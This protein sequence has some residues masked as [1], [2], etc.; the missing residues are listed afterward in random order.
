MRGIGAKPTA[1]MVNGS[2][3]TAV[4]EQALAG[5]RGGKVI[6][7]R[8]GQAFGA[9]DGEAN[10]IVGELTP[11]TLSR[12]ELGQALKDQSELLKSQTK[13]RKDYLYQRAG[14][15]TGDAPAAG[16]NTRQYMETL[17]AERKAMGQSAALNNGRSIETI[18]EQADA[19][20]KDIGR[21]ANFNA[22]KQAR[23]SIGAIAND[24]GADQV[25]RE[26][27]QGLYGALTKDMGE[28]AESAG[29]GALQA[30]KMANNYNRRTADPKSMFH[31]KT[32]I[33]PIIKAATPEQAAD[34]VL[35]QV[36]KG[37]TRLNAVRRQIERT[38]GGTELWNTLTGSTVERMGITR[39]VDG[40]EAFN[41]T[42]MLNSWKKLSPEAKAAM[43][44]GTAR[45]QYQADLDRLARVADNMKNYRRLDNH[46]NTNKAAS[47]LGE[48][49]PFDKTTL[50]GTAFMGP[51][52]MA[53]SV[54]GKAANL[55]YK[56]WQAKMLTDPKTVNWLSTVP[57]AEMQKGGLKAHLGR[58]VEIAGQ[59][60]D[61]A[62]RVAINQYIREVGYTE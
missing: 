33:D 55:G 49:N 29:D 2:A 10:R 7:D 1:G 27:A 42:Q 26:R 3:G 46:S 39:G 47:A 22:L 51:K 21:G 41:P 14:E 44:K 48:L 23:T 59:T 54:A 5:T 4:K 60:S 53:I 8:I 43:F 18:I 45:Q 57:A 38:E 24:P 35:A 13:A 62:L 15:L 50:I 40:I 28:T 9:M 17:L 52:A 37:G 30:W 58:L 6:Q 34:W 25:L 61:Q 16:S 11:Q 31:E 19:I 20:S 32:T 12:Q 36:N 56:R